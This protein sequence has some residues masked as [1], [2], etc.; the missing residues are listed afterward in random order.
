MWV[1]FLYYVAQIGC[2]KVMCKSCVLNVGE[3]NPWWSQES[4]S[5]IFLICLA[6]FDKGEEERAG[7]LCYHSCE[8]FCPTFSSQFSIFTPTTQTL[9]HFSLNKLSFIL[10]TK[11]SVA[12]LKRCICITLISLNTDFAIQRK[13]LHLQHFNFLKL[14]FYQNQFC[15]RTSKYWFPHLLNT[16]LPKKI[17]Y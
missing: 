17:C 7:G 5:T 11:F 1:F 8:T 4:V 12:I 14:S 3:I 9:E 16:F 2:K 15:S 13:K 6:Y 10:F